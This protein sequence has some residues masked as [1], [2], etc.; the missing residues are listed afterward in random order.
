MRRHPWIRTGLGPMILVGLGLLLPAPA[1]GGDVL[2]E[3][4]LVAS[5]R[6]KSD[7]LGHALARSGD[8]L[9]AAAPYADV[10]G[11]R[12]AGAVYV[13]LRDPVTGDWAEHKKLVSQDRAVVDTFGASIAADGDT[14]AVGRPNAD[15][16]G[17]VSQ[18]TVHVFRRHAGGTDN[19]GEVVTLTDGSV[20]VLGGFG[21][22]VALAGDLL[23]VG[24]DRRSGGRVTLFERGRG[25]EDAWGKVTT[26]LESDVGG[27]GSGDGSTNASFGAAVALDGDLLLIGATGADVSYHNEN[28]GAA[29]LFARDAPDRDRW[30]YVTR[31]IAP[32]AALCFGGRFLLDLALEPVE[33]QSEVERC[34]REDSTSDGDGFGAALALD[35]DTAVIGA[36]S[37]GGRDG[38]FKVGAAYVF[39]R[40]ARL[41]GQ[42][43]AGP[44]LAPS[45]FQGPAFFGGALALAGDA[46]LVGAASLDI[47]L[48]ESQGAAYV[49]ER[50]AG[51]SGQW[52]EVEKLIAADGLGRHNF[53][54]AVALDGPTRLVGAI[55]Q[56]DFRGAVYVRDPS[57]DPPDDPPDEPP[58]PAFP[59][60]GELVDA[61][62]VEGPGGALLGAVMG[63]LPEPLPV[64]IVEVPTPAEPMPAQAV[65]LGAV[66]NVGAAGTTTAAA[67]A[68]FALLLPVPEGA[69]TAHLAAAVL[70]Q[71]NSALD[72]D[73][74]LGSFWTPVRGVYD[75]GSRVFIVTLDALAIEG[76]TVV[77]M[78]HPDVVPVDPA[79]ASSPATRDAG[80]IFEVRCFNQFDAPTCDAADEEKFAVL[81]REAY[82]DFVRLGFRDPALSREVVGYE[83]LPDGSRQLIVVDVAKY[84]NISIVERGSCT[85]SMY[86]NTPMS[87]IIEF[88]YNKEKAD[89]VLTKASVRHELFH[90]FQHGGAARTVSADWSAIKGVA[91][92]DRYPHDGW[93]EFGLIIE[94]TAAAA[95]SSADAMARTQLHDLRPFWLTSPLA[96]YGDP[97]LYESQDFWVYFGR[98]RGLGLGYLNDLFQRGATI[99]AA[100]EFFAQGQNPPTSLADEYWGWSKNQGFEKTIALDEAPTNPC[101]FDPS[102]ASQ[103]FPLPEIV[104][105]GPTRG[106]PLIIDG[107]LQRLQAG[108]VKITFQEA[109]GSITVEANRKGPAEGLAYRVYLEGEA[110]C[111]QVTDTRPDSAPRHFARVSPGETIY[112]IVANVQHQR[113]AS[114]EYEVRLSP[115][116]G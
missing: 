16:A 79:A 7:Q 3:P 81:M 96:R 61:G 67:G 86:I 73:T 72:D 101:H 19:W 35:G 18:G 40:D 20:G 112:V 22:S 77:L 21:A 51:G 104:Y 62:S 107:T 11:V 8:V 76:A 84:R 102:V 10:D 56:E 116:L 9:I 87:G 53:G 42:W 97:T 98:K 100:A 59:P 47:G 68:R 46:V 33:V 85:R 114:L 66:L 30:S 49:F 23:A 28:D 60:T 90:A 113:G 2:V 110:D 36:R 99:T 105:P 93:G 92:N 82:D 94:G 89:D 24:T 80:P 75:A 55:G 48:K 54:S 37:T 25:G 34:A 13:F 4:K 1:A 95:E 5:D 39:E 91:E 109:A 57:A 88:C 71:A 12:L 26:V 38:N 106:V 64:W 69:D 63:A 108:V 6:A 44:K 45:D 78:Q 14:V 17:V 83:T 74:G 27:T 103:E 31:L 58:T 32:E 50:D 111:G 115:P 70:V 43:T 65:A 52:G 15:V 41:G 29:Y